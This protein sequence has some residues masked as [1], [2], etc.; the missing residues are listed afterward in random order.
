MAETIHMESSIHSAEPQKNV[1]QNSH[2]AGLATTEI[3]P[4]TA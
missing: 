2:Q 1:E 4:R 3:R